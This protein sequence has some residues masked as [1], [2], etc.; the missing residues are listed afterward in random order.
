MRKTLRSVCSRDPEIGFVVRRLVP[1]LIILGAML[2]A[3]ALTPEHR[4]VGRVAMI[5]SELGLKALI[6][7]CFWLTIRRS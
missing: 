6:F 7:T 2:L 5:V 4:G 1:W 3:L